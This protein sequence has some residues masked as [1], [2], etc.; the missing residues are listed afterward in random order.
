MPGAWTVVDALDEATRDEVVA[1]LDA[2]ER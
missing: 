1:L 2:V